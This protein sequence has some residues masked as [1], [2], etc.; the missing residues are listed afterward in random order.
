MPSEDYDNLTFFGLLLTVAIGVLVGLYWWGEPARMEASAEERRLDRVQRG[1]L[2]Y[3]SNCVACHGLNGEG[4]SGL[5][6]ALNAQSFL[7]AADDTLVFDT[8][9]DGRPNTAMPAWGQAGGG[10]FTDEDIRDLSAFIRAWEATAPQGATSPS[11]GDPAAG[12]VTFSNVCYVCHGVNG[13]GTPIAPALND[14]QRLAQFDDEWYR[15]TIREGRPARGMPTWGKV[16]SPQQIED[17]VAFLRGWQTAA[18]AVAPPALSGDPIRGAAIF[19][20]TCIA[21]HG[22]AGAGTERGPALND[23]SVLGQLTDEALQRVISEG[24]LEQGMPEWGRVLSPAE[25]GDLVAYLRS[26]QSQVR[27]SQAM[28]GDLG[29]GATIYAAN[30]AVCHGVE[31][32]GGIGPRLNPNDFIAAQTDAELLA[33]IRAGRPGTVMAGYADRLTSSQLTDLVALLRAWTR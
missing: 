19:S 12:A 15:E 14:P 21:C 6:P 25:I 18:P 26:W 16:L 32:E 20:A 5:G 27:E 1:S 33:F 13:E 7:S 17:L 24:I 31:G 28:P 22:P 2:L 29:R 8:I 10:P 3:E 23:A 9:R 11:R 4:I 30:C